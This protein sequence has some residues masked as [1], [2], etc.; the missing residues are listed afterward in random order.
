[1]TVRNSVRN[2]RLGSADHTID[3]LESS[4]NGDERGKCFE[5]HCSRAEV[6]R[7]EETGCPEVSRPSSDPL[8]TSLPCRN[9]SCKL[10]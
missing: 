8:Y 4:K 5:S 3:D 7:T 2:E 9:T 1:M 6:S 10:Y